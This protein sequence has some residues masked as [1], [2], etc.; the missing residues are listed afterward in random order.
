MISLNYQLFHKIHP[1]FPL[2]NKGNDFSLLT[3]LSKELKMQLA[4]C[5]TDSLQAL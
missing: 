1:D 4:L 3:L 5:S 2:P